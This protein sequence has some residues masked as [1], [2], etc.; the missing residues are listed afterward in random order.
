[1]RRD[2]E[3]NPAQTSAPEK[4]KCRLDG[5]GAAGIQTKDI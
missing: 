3:S 4:A 5:L 1:M 2:G